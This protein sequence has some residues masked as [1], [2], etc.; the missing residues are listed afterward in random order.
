[1]KAYSFGGPNAT[2]TANKS[3][4]GLTAT[5]AVRPAIFDITLGSQA[6]PA[7]QAAL[8]LLGRFTAAGTSTAKT[9]EPHD[10]ADV[11]SVGIAGITHSA[12]PTYT[13]DKNLLRIGLN[14]RG[15]YRWV[16]SPDREF[17]CPATAANG[18]GLYLSAATASMIAECVI[19]FI[20]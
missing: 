1:M 16:A 15:T 9:P 14:Q 11:A 20:E 4:A 13:A 17:K 6:T 2:G 12:E 8:F 7:D 3:L 10:P 5:S 18:L 19:A